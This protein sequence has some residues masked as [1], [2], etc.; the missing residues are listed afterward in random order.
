[1][2][3][4]GNKINLWRYHW[5]FYNCRYWWCN[6]QIKMGWRSRRRILNRA[7]LVVWYYYWESYIL[8]NPN[9]ILSR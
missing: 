2:D 1:M 7:I 8:K 5:Y 4:H 6:V 3:S 9:S